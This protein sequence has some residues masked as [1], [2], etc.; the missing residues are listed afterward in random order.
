MTCHTVSIVATE[1]R[2]KSV[3]L[4]AFRTTLPPGGHEWHSGGWIWAK[5]AGHQ[6]GSTDAL[7]SDIEGRLARRPLLVRRKGAVAQEVEIGLAGLHRT[8][9]QCSLTPASICDFADAYGMLGCGHHVDFLAAPELTEAEWRDWVKSPRRL[10]TTF[11]TGSLRGEPLVLWLWALRNVK[12]LVALWDLC[13][14]DSRTSSCDPE[15]AWITAKIKGRFLLALRGEP[16]YDADQRPVREWR[17]NSA[18]QS[19]WESIGLRHLAT[20]S[21]LA[22][23]RYCASIA[24]LSSRESVGSHPPWRPRTSS[25]RSTWRLPSMSWAA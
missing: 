15:L 16:L 17:R 3:G 20:S 21:S 14:L 22:S 8:F 13:E 23:M 12:T 7:E 2:R 4:F 19:R 11:T 10:T 24:S 6:L 25:G 1:K 18:R 5:I 9:A